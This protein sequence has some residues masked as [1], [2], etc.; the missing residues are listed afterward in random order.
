MLPGR[1]LFDDL[2]DDDLDVRRPQGML[3]DIYE[4]D[5]TYHIDIDAPGFKKDDIKIECDQG[6]LK[7][8]AERHSEDKENKKF[9]HRER[10]TY[11][12]CER[13]F[14]LGN[15]NEEQIQA[16]FKD[17]ILSITVPKQDVVETK[18]TITIN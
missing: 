10:K 3:C 13:S 1:I 18:K 11:E 15:V 16:S 8:I 14:Y 12:K 4:K 6:N 9:L 7:I 17:G 5:N 2:F